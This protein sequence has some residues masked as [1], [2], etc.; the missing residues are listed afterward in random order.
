MSTIKEQPAPR[1]PHTA[2]EAPVGETVPSQM[3]GAGDDSSDDG[4]PPEPWKV[5]LQ[6]GKSSLL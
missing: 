1:D 6:G 2:Y 5:Q 4:T 3:D